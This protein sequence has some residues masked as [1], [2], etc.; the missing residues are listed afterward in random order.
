MITIS[1]ILTSD[2]IWALDYEALGSDINNNFW[3][4]DMSSDLVKT[5]DSEIFSTSALL[6]FVTT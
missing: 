3:L 1:E 4:W 2:D 6:A 5:S